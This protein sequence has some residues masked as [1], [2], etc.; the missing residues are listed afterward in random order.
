MPTLNFTHFSGAVPRYNGYTLEQTDGVL[1][2][3]PKSLAVRRYDPFGDVDSLLLDVVQAG[4]V[5]A[6]CEPFLDYCLAHKMLPLQDVDFWRC[7]DF[8]TAWPDDARPIL[9]ALLAFAG[10]YGSDRLP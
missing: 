2:L 9:D 4:A 3:V 7:G 10:K 6:N 1:Y 5:I 8:F